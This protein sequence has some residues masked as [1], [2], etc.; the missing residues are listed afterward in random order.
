MPSNV[1]IDAGDSDNESYSGEDQPPELVESRAHIPAL[2][3]HE[4][5]AVEEIK[6]ARKVPITIIT[7]E[8]SDSA[9]VDI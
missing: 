7:G 1:D 6:E 5:E 9:R 8:S 3:P 4:A 2:V